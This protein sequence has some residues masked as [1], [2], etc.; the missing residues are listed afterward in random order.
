MGQVMR[1]DMGVRMMMRIGQLVAVAVTC[2]LIIGCG[3]AFSVKEKGE[4]SLLINDL[5]RP[6]E[7]RLTVTL[8]DYKI[9]SGT[10]QTTN[11]EIFSS[12]I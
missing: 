1:A 6:I 12:T 7:S 2:A 4:F 10:Q 11:M 9:G 3:D 5:Q 8:P